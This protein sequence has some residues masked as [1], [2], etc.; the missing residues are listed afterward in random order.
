MRR[1]TLFSPL[2]RQ[3]K[4]HHLLLGLIALGVFA[5]MGVS[6][7][8]AMPS[9]SGG[10]GGTVYN[11]IP[12]KLPGSVPSQGFECCQT[13]GFGDEVGLGGKART[14]Q[15]MSAVLVSW[16]CQN[17]HWYSGDCSTTPGATFSVP[18]TFTIY[19]DNASTPGAVLAQATQTVNVLYR[20][21]ANT[22]KCGDG[23]WYDSQDHTCYNGF[24]QTIKMPVT[25]TTL[26]DQVIWSVAYNTTTAGHTPVGPSACNI[27]SGG[28]GYDSLNV[29]AWSA[30]N[31]PYTGTDT[32]E[33]QAFRCVTLLNVC[34]MENGWTGYRPLGA[35][36]ATK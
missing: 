16:G 9:S 19:E 34:S 29:G 30:P 14:P 12:S 23:R 25:G 5:I 32:N 33:D 26:P 28:C 13:S 11:A 10:S 8:A 18:I 2:R 15:S 31:A 22:A 4:I 27:S 6:L 7:A 3:S 17:G 21:S 36:D 20:P 24:A 35:I 1:P